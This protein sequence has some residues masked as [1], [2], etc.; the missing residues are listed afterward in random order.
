[1]RLLFFHVPGLMLSATFL[2]D[3]IS[4][5]TVSDSLQDVTFD[6]SNNE[7]VWCIEDVDALILLNCSDFRFR[8]VISTRVIVQAETHAIAPTVAVLTILQCRNF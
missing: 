2:L 6:R 4:N 7:T 5:P 1:M 3:R 8:P